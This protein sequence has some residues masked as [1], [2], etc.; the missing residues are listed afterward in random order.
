L[1]NA[2]TSKIQAHKQSNDSEEEDITSYWKQEKAA[3]ELV[4]QK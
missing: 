3:F 2:N 4:L 1:R